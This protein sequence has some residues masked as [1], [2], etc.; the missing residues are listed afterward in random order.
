MH[1]GGPYTHKIASHVNDYGKPA[2]LLVNFI[3]DLSFFLHSDEFLLVF[4]GTV[5]IYIYGNNGNIFLPDNPSG[6]CRRYWNL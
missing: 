1:T 5:Q 2:V 6:D 4:T 3:I